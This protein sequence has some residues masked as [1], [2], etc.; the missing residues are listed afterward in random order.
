MTIAELAAHLARL[1]TIEPAVANA[2][3]VYDDEDKPVGG[4]I[5]GRKD[6]AWTLLLTPIPLD[7]VGGF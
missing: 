1:Q 3:I 5:L 7:Q 2:R 6:G 4:G